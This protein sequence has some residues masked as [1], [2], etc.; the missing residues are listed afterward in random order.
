MDIKHKKICAQSLFYFSGIV[1][2]NIGFDSVA[3]FNET[4]KVIPSV[5]FGAIL[6]LLSR[7]YF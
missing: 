7:Y 3:L 2:H 4:D 6:I 1:A 5:H